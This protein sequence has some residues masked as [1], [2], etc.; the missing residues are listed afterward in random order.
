MKAEEITALDYVFDAYDQQY[1][2]SIDSTEYITKKINIEYTTYHKMLSIAD[3]L[4]IS[5]QELIIY[6][7]ILYSNEYKLNARQ[8]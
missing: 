3:D 7:F 2:D 4:Q 1:S 6:L 8:G 5:I